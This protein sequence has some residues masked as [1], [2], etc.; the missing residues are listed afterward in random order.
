MKGLLGKLSNKFHQVQDIRKKYKEE[1]EAREKQAKS[2]IMSN[3]GTEQIVE[4]DVS[5][6]TIVKI[7]FIVAIF[8]AAQQIFF[9]LQ[10]VLIIAAIA[11]FL[12]IGLSPAVT[13]LESFK[14]PRPL[15]I[16][17]LY[18]IFFGGL[19]V[20]F[21]GVIPILSEQLMAIAHDVSVYINSSEAESG[22]IKD[23]L[24]KF[25]VGFDTQ[26][27]QQWLS[28]NLEVISRNLQSAAGSAFSI[29]SNVFKGVFNLIF[30]LVLLFFIL[31]ERENISQ[32]I[33][34]LFLP[35]DRAYLESRA[36]SVQRKMFAWFKAQGI[37]MLSVGVLMYAGMKILEWTLG[38][39][40]A[41]TI[42]LMAGFMELFPYIGVLVTGILA[43]L[44]AL[45]ISWLLLLIVIIWIGFIQF[46]EGNV[47][48]PMVMEKVIG[49]SSVATLLALSIGGIL[50]NALGGVPLAI[51]GMIFS[52][53]IA[54]SISIF[55]EEYVKKRRT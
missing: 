21:V 24:E 12:A 54:A 16:L 30:A 20:L 37:L 32:F 6:K 8:L 51:L 45:N 43:G 29:M 53:P 49:L 48:V 9:Q 38:M 42:G 15:A 33:L 19:G 47:L 23:N 55:V 39:Q 18:V 50:G 1:K 36:E 10:S 41:A 4:F 35:K 52:V 17:I 22:W 44:V 2:S 25:G 40:Y 26:S 46:L 7:L 14:I 11:F 13:I 27:V 34:S 31:L 5:A 28:S 3:S